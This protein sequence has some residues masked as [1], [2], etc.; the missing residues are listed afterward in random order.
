MTLQE[1]YEPNAKRIIETLSARWLEDKPKP[2][3]IFVD[4]GPYFTSVEFSDFLAEIGI[5]LKDAA[6]QAPWQHG[7][8]EA[9]IGLLK[10]TLAKLESDHPDMDPGVLLSLAVMG[11]NSQ[12]SIRGF[13]PFQWAYG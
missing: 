6:G 4:E 11:H 5:L 3:A 8:A 1:S 12:S 13:T 2:E 9:H 7:M 10:K